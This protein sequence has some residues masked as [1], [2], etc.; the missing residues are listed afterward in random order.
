MAEDYCLTLA[1]NFVQG[2]MAKETLY[3]HVYAADDADAHHAG[4][5][6]Q[7]AAEHGDGPARVA[8][9]LPRNLGHPRKEVLLKI[10]EEKGAGDK[11][12]RAVQSLQCQQCSHFGA[13]KTLSPAH[14]ET[15]TRFGAAVQADTL[16][17]EN[18]K[19]EVQYS[20]GLTKIGGRQLLADRFR[21]H[22]IR[23]TV[24]ESFVAAKRKTQEE[25]EVR[26]RRFAQSKHQLATFVFWRGSQVAY[27]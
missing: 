19:K 20:D 5:L 16:W 14:L 8:I 22:M 26:S 15:A 11:V 23:L 12:K 27:Y 24:D 25:Q 6:R 10:V 1:K 4:L 13:K 7:L 9:K 17:V 3:D 18:G 21:T 2:M